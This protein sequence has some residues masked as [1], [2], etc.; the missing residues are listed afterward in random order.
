MSRFRFPLDPVLRMRERA[1]R[2]RLAEVAGLE[3]ERSRLE[4]A[5]RRE[6]ATISH[7]QQGQRERLAGR[8]DMRELR[9]T[10]AGT[11]GA[12]RRAGR[13][14]VE[15]AGVYRRIEEARGRLVDASR[16]RRAVERLRERRLEAFRREEGRREARRLDDVATEA[17]RRHAGGR[18]R[19][20][21]DPVAEPGNGP[22]GPARP[23]ATGIGREDAA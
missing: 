6:Q 3:Q 1:E 22:G 4:D 7:G 11:L 21:P 10:A 18:R 2:E 15:L 8:V 12:M 16:D 13:L 20:G 19:A 9:S 14:A 17:W 23:P 5:I